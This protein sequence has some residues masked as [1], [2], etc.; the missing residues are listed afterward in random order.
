MIRGG[1]DGEGEEGR[2]SG[3]VIE[4]KTE[5]GKSDCKFIP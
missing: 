4:K 1:G 5:N 2:R 3:G